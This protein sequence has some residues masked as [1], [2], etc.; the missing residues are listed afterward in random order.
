MLF[1]DRRL[2][3][4]C[5]VAGQVAIHMPSVG[6]DQVFPVCPARLGYVVTID[7]PRIVQ[8]HDRRA[9]SL[10]WDK[11][12]QTKQGVRCPL[13]ADSGDFVIQQACPLQEASPCLA[14]DRADVTAEKS[15]VRTQIRHDASELVFR[16]AGELC[17]QIERKLLAAP[18][19]QTNGFNDESQLPVLEPGKGEYLNPKPPRHEFLLQNTQCISHI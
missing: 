1:H 10:P 7:N 11:V 6:S 19:S 3:N 15:L 16:M 12:S 2:C 17:H 8:E 13:A 18:G 5:D 4:D 14:G 9:Y